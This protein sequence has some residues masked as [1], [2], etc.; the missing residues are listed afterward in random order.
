MIIHTHIYIYR[1][2][3]LEVSNWI[4]VDSYNKND[5]W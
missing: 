4:Q 5:K 3:G 2:L 1:I